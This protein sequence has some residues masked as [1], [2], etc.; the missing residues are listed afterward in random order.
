VKA[1]VIFF[2]RPTAAKKPATNRLW[3]YDL[4]TNFHVPL[5]TIP[6]QRT[7]LDEFVV[8]FKAENRQ[9]RRPTWTEQKPNGRW[10]SFPIKDLTR[11]DKCSLDITR[12]TDEDSS[13]ATKLP[14][15]SILAAEI[16]DEL[17]A[18]LAQ[19]EDIVED[20]NCGR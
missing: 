8:C 17:Q 9:Q 16:V 6:L 13:D 12:L 18:A 2:D 11:R 14:R 1:N 5:K 3:V 20:L 7:D 15:P 10:R 4:R 19:L